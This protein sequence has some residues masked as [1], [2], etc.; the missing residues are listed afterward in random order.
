MC[1]LWPLTMLIKK[2][3]NTE[4]INFYLKNITIKSF[5]LWHLKPNDEKFDNF[6]LK[7]RLF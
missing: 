7:P 1:T 2:K 4:K 5:V 3:K 6:A